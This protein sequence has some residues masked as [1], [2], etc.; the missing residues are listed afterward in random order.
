MDWFSPRL[1]LSCSWSATSH[2]INRVFWGSNF[3]SRAAL[4]LTPASRFQ[5]TSATYGQKERNRDPSRLVKQADRPTIQRQQE[6][7]RLDLRSGSLQIGFSV[8][9]F[10]VRWSAPAWTALEAARRAPGAQP[11]S[12]T[13]RGLDW[14]AGLGWAVRLAALT[15]APL[16]SSASAEA[17]PMPWAAPVTSATLPFTCMSPPALGGRARRLRAAAA[18][19]DPA[20]AHVWPGR[21]RPPVGGDEAVKQRRHPGLCHLAL[22]APARRSLP[23]WLVAEPGSLPLH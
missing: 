19:K 6:A 20:R 2:W 18:F 7:P 14:R 3:S 4:H 13:P 5:S 23:S 1:P 21:A 16:S 22:S 9:A 11:G 8:S 15:L 10:E 17:R 12:L